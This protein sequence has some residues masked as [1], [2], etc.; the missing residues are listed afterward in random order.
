MR[1]IYILI[2]SNTFYS[3]QIISQD[4]LC[5]HHYYLD[6]HGGVKEGNK[7]FMVSCSCVGEILLVL[8]E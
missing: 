3:C 8:K 4:E 2:Y 7:L 6:T 5:M 1:Q